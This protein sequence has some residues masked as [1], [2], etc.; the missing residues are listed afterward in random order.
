MTVSLKHLTSN[1]ILTE[2]ERRLRV[3]QRLELR[4]Y[5][6][7]KRYIWHRSEVLTSDWH[8]WIEGLLLGSLDTRWE[9]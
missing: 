1:T 4:S 3:W 8:L 7:S 9:N 2:N 6:P 5:W